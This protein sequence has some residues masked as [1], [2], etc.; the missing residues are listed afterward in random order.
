MDN[1]HVGLRACDCELRVASF[2]SSFIHLLSYNPYPDPP[3]LIHQR[4]VVYLNLGITGLFVTASATHPPIRHNPPTGVI[5]PITLP[6][7]CGSKTSKYK[8][9]ENGAATD[10]KVSTAE[11]MSWY[12]AAV[13]QLAVR[14]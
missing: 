14:R 10:A 5:G 6:N 8:L 4:S 1:T 2:P 11:W 9:P 3:H 7:L 13:P 12:W